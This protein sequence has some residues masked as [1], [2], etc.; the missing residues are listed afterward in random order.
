MTCARCGKLRMTLWLRMS[1]KGNVSVCRG[2]EL[3]NA[4]Y[5]ILC[6]GRF[7]EF[8]KA[9][10][11]PEHHDLVQ[12][13]TS[14]AKDE[15]MKICPLLGMAKHMSQRVCVEV[16]WMGWRA[17]GK[18]ELTVEYGGLMSTDLQTKGIPLVAWTRLSSTMQQQTPIRVVIMDGLGFGWH[19]GIWRAT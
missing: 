2:H 3:A 17:D 4:L 19:G 11:V 1:G 6:H 12:T 13:S 5:A 18:L 15:W 7:M 10:N 14:T 16:W 9:V 8:T